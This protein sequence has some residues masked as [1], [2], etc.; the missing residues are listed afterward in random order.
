MASY[1]SDTALNRSANAQTVNDVTVQLHDGAPGND[2]MD[3]QIAGASVVVAAAGW[4]DAAAGVSQTVAVTPFDVLS[5]V[6]DSTVVAYSCL[7]GADFLGWG[8]FVNPIAVPANNQFTADAG[9][10]RFVV[11]R[12]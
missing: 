5:A 10:I 7:D 8:D 4:T 1:M 2:G 12:P 3:N 9:T 6:D 11:E